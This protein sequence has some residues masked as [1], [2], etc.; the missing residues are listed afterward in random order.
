MSTKDLIEEIFGDE[1]VDE[2]DTPTPPE[3]QLV[4]VIHDIYGDWRIYAD[5]HEEYYSIGD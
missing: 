4:K 2:D 5:G 3:R 1:F